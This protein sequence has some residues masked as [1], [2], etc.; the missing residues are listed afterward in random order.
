M[1]VDGRRVEALNGRTVDLICPAD[2][3]V[4]ATVP[5]GDADDVAR[6]TASARTAFDTG[7]WRHSSPRERAAALLRC[8]TAISDHVDQLAELE[9]KNTGKPRAE[10]RA[11]AVGAAYVFEYYAGWVTKIYGSQIPVPGDFLDVTFREPV[12]VCAGIIPWNFP[13]QMAAWKVAPALA[14]G[15]S[16][17]LKPSELTP[18]SA[19]LLAELASDGG[20]PPGWFNVVLGDGPTVGAALVESPNIDKIAF[21]GSTKVGREIASRAART[22]KRVSLELGGKSPAIV[23][24]DADL[25][26][27]ANG[28]ADG[29][30]YNAGQVCDAR[31]R[32][33]VHESIATE[34]TSAFADASA[35]FKPGPPSAP[36]TT[37][38]PLIS[39]AHL[40]RVA[41]YVR[42]ARNEA[43]D[44][45]FGGEAVPGGGYFFEPTAFSNVDMNT[46]IAR[47]EIFGPVAVVTSFRDEE[48][49]VAAANDST[50]G[51]A[52]TI[53]TT[54]VPRAITLAREIRAGNISINGPEFL[55]P[56]HPFGGFKESGVGRELGAAA[57]DIYTETK[58]L[59]I[60]LSPRT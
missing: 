53:W 21:T 13:L 32:V 19:L 59:I 41:E 6:A 35:E 12:G 55:G 47:E 26:A 33:L 20:V 46:R 23:L 11:A 15:N 24:A 8:A 18:L 40:R 36:E 58:N 28:V 29:V 54:D 57:L 2:G 25:E 7:V 9:T 43:G 10:A 14:C 17:V 60:A 34:F 56:E 1:Y 22:L 48:S 42:I 39:E 3:A 37:M 27:A 4:A 31:T 52:A 38:G 51:L 30:F 45:L 50:Y 5:D 16:I 44:P 49:I